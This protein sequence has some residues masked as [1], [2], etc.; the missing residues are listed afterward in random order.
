MAEKR[1][2]RFICFCLLSCSN[3]AATTEHVDGWLKLSVKTQIPYQPSLTTPFQS[4]I[5][6][7]ISS[8]SLLQNHFL[9]MER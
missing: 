2:A 3:E 9:L 7:S 5:H 1:I 8:L 6:N 4:V